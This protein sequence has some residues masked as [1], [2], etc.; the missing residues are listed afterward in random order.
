LAHY[1]DSLFAPRSI[2]VVGASEREGSLGRAVF[3][4]LRG[5]IEGAAG[6]AADD[7]KPHPADKAAASSGLP[8]SAAAA[9]RAGQPHSAAA[10]PHAGQ[11]HPA[12]TAAYGNPSPAE[13]A[14]RYTGILYPINP[15]HKQVAGIA[16]H[17]R[18][19]QLASALKA[20]GAAPPD[21][22][23]I[24][25][26][27]PAVAGVLRDAGAAGIKHAVV[28]S[29]GFDAGDLAGAALL[30]EAAEA[31][32]AAGVRLLGPHSMGLMRPSLNLNATFA[33]GGARPGG[34]ALISQS[35][36]VA[37][38]LADWAWAAGI[39]FS[40]V[41]ATGAAVDIDFGEILDYLMFDAETQ[42]IL[43][44]VEGIHD[45][46]RFLSGLRACARTKP[47]VVLKAGRHTSRNA[48]CASDDAPT[49][50]PANA[51]SHTGSLLGDDAVFGAAL[52]RSGVARAD[53]YSALFAIARLL[54]AGRLPKGRRLAI[55]SNGGGPG[56]MAADRACDSE[57]DIAALSPETLKQLDTLLPAHWSRANPLSLAGDATPAHYAA[58]LKHLLADPGIDGVL[59]LHSPQRVTSSV[60]AA[61]AILPLAL[62]ARKP[63]LTAWLGEAE[64]RAGR[65]II[66]QA[67]MPAFHYPESGVLAFAA[68][69]DY[70]QAQ[71][72]LL[73][74]PPPLASAFPADL[75]G[76]HQ[77]ARETVTAGRTVLNESESKQLLADFGIPTPR[78]AIAADLEQ[79][80]LI[81]ANIGYPLALKIVSPDVTHKSDVGGVVLN[82]RD[83]VSLEREFTALL[84]RV[85]RALPGA[86]LEGVA[87]Q[88]MIAKRYGRELL[89]GVARDPVFGQVIT[90]GAGGVAVEL[91]GD[92]NVALPPL[93]PRLADEL[94]SGTRIA[95]LLKAYRHIPAAD[96]AALI[97]VLI[98]VSEMVCALPWLKEMDI[99]PLVVD[100]H[101]A[102]ALDARVV[103]D[104]DR[105]A[106]DLRYSHMAIHPYPTALISHVTLRDGTHL[107][108][109]PIRPEDAGIERE[110]VEGLSEQ[111]RYM[112]FFNP[113]KY[114]PPRLLSRL[115]QVDYDRE[116]AL[117]ATFGEGA[118][119]K[120][121][122]VVRYSPNADGT[123]AE[124]AVTVGD[125]WHGKGLGSLLMKRLI[126][127][128][129][130]AGYQRL[131]G[132]V[133]E[134]NDKMHLLMRKLGFHAGAKGEDKSVAEYV[135]DLTQPEGMEGAGLSPASPIAPAH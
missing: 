135:F 42:S 109:R 72:M 41:I 113:L 125:A 98:K 52:R 124:F 54:A 31:A 82:V 128:A 5:P 71:A 6:A 12:A 30:R 55:V 69:A 49:G 58:A 61:Q 134:S 44:Y 67:G 60:Q 59:T 120:I 7:G 10:A 74:V 91:L 126:S 70:T 17:A 18:L 133:L 127:A 66:E 28:L 39:G 94:I 9:P 83:A 86:R 101:G 65:E 100:A 68:L 93:S 26:P 38:A 15:K 46:R 78:I 87:I 99:N 40:S 16:C 45:A 4:N 34:L 56:T 103:I 77:L 62:D 90:F 111:S 73:E 37:A 108:L 29:A 106:D 21:L 32:R 117:L 110:F 114:I 1:L 8:H 36:A 25:T 88:P 13:G 51:Q 53:S 80:R 81:A 75:A 102:I 76:A 116:L 23:V 122:G 19:P 48:R 84:E 97:D 132:S 115:T 14:A 118:D 11:P 121:A 2:A 33:R 92:H 50:P 57:L 96:H 89:I 129:R 47:I 112:R 95:A 107:L 3:E 130:A 104:P 27:A 85:A 22:A 20:Q 119:E 64:A 24:V 79:A 131:T 105:L 123:S 63:V 35:G 43:L